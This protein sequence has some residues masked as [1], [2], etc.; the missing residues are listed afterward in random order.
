MNNVCFQR[1]LPETKELIQRMLN[2][3]PEKRITPTEALNHMYF[4]KLGFVCDEPV[5]TD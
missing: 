3:N 4:K 5:T 2:K 1:F